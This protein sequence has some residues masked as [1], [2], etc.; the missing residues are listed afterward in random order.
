[1]FGGGLYVGGFAGFVFP[2]P[3][4][5][6]LPCRRSCRLFSPC[7][8]GRFV[9]VGGPC[10]LGLPCCVSGRLSRAFCAGPWR[11]GGAIL[12]LGRSTC[13]FSCCWTR[14][15]SEIA[16]GLPPFSRTISCC[17]AKATGAGGGAILATTGRL[18]I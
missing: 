17:L 10:R 2:G 8:F 7:W 5:F 3:G 4:R 11:T 9:L 16:G 18:I 15:I 6:Q 14:R 13:A 1:M 12:M